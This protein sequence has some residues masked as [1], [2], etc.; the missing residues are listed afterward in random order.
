MQDKSKASR[1]RPVP[2]NIN[3]IGIWSFES[4]HDESFFM[5]KTSHSF[6]KLL[7][8]R[9]GEGTIEFSERSVHCNSGDLV[10]VCPRHRHRIIDYPTRPISL[11][12]TGIRLDWIKKLPNTI[13]SFSSG[14]YRMNSIQRSH[15]EQIFRR[16][17]YL[18]DQTDSTSYLASM[19]STFGLLSEISILLSTTQNRIRPVGIPDEPIDPM[20]EN[21]LNW[22]GR[23]FYEAISLEEGATASGMSR[24]TFT[25]KFKQRTGTTWLDYV[26]RLRIRHAVE[27]LQGTD[28]KISSIA[29]QSGF[30]DLSTFYRTFTKIMNQSPGDL[31][32]Q[33]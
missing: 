15:I 2:P 27:L 4:R 20:L 7:F 29:F 21:Y 3:E 30:D 1:N 19:A 12:G 5:E 10:I 24:R 31:R 16:L 18:F 6:L 17:L 14:I 26:N 11:Y 9:E 25:A 33:K 32:N 22:L 23:N 28:R 8:I 13:D